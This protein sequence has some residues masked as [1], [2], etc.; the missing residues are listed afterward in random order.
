MLPDRISNPVWQHT[1]VSPSAFDTRSGNI[2]S[3]LLPLFQENPYQERI[4]KS[5]K[6]SASAGPCHSVIRYSRKT[7]TASYPGPEVIKE[8]R[9]NLAEDEFFPAHKLL[10]CQQ[11]SDIF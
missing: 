3:F 4:N 11:L 6:K 2:L 1:F 8:I 7:P 5:K 9:L 10:K